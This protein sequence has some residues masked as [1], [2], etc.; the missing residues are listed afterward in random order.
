VTV[1]PRARLGQPMTKRECE[2]LCLMTTG[3][4][5]EEIAGR[6]YIS[7]STVHQYIKQAKL[8]TGAKTTHQL[9]A[10]YMQGA[11]RESA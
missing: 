10:F 3:L 11:G 7:T 2:V 4:T 9:V 5:T 1:S 8:K 6:M